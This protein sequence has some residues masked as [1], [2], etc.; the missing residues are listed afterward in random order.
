VF[1]KREE[2][3]QR[4]LKY[5][6]YK[7]GCINI[8]K[9]SL[10]KAYFILASE[11]KYIKMSFSSIAPVVKRRKKKR[12]FA[13]L[14]NK[15]DI[16][17]FYFPKEEGFVCICRLFVS[18]RRRARIVDPADTHK[19]ADDGFSNDTAN[20]RRHNLRERKKNEL[21]VFGLPW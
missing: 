9:I 5:Y 20:F 14:Y 17:L 15:T 19:A 18:R 4:V 13:K 7:V 21:D 16:F 6:I 3:S 8:L 2:T 1:H 11:P 12:T 10:L